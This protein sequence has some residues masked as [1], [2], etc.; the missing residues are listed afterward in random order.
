MKSKSAFKRNPLAASIGLE[1]LALGGVLASQLLMAPLVAAAPAGGVIVGGNGSINLGRTTNIEQT[2]H[3]LAINWDS[4]NV[5]S[6]EKVVFQQPDASALVLNRIL[7]QNPSKIRGSIVAN[8]NVLL[9][10]PRGIMFTETATVNVGGLVASGLDVSVDDFMNGNLVFKGVDGA[11]G[12]VINKGVINASSAAL[13]GKTVHNAPNALISADL[14]ALAAGDEAL[15]T[16][17]A[18]GLMGVKVTKEVL[19]NDL[20]LDDA[21]LN[22]GSIKGNK[23]LLEAAVSRD[24]FSNAVNNQGI[25]RAEGIDVSGGTIRLLGSGGQVTNG[26]D[27]SASGVSGGSISLAGDKIVN[28]GRM[29]AQGSAGDAQAIQID[30]RELHN[31]ST[32]DG[33]QGGM[34]IELGAEGGDSH[35]ILGNLTAADTITVTARGGEAGTDSF[36]FAAGGHY[37]L[38][39][40]GTV[41]TQGVTISGADKID[42]GAAGVLY[43]RDDVAESFTITGDQKLR[44]DAVIFS[45]IATV[46]AG[47]GDVNDSV[48]GAAQWALQGTKRASARGILF[49]DIEQVNSDGADIRITGRDQVAESFV[50]TGSRK[51]MVDEMTFSGV[52]A[53]NAGSG[54]VTDQVSGAV[55]WAL[56]GD[57]SV[58]AG[59]MTFRD[60]ENVSGSGTG[61][62]LTG[63]NDVAE[64]FAITGSKALTANRI[65]FDNISVVNAGSGAEPDRVT[66][67][68]QWLLNGNQ[69]IK[70]G[71]MTFSGVEAVGSL[72]DNSQLSGNVNNT[73]TFIL[74]GNNRLTASG[75]DFVGVDSVIGQSTDRVQD[76]G[77]LHYQLHSQTEARV[78]NLHLQ[79]LAL[80]NIQWDAGD[81]I[82]VAADH[83]LSGKT[84]DSKGAQIIGSGDADAFTVTG[85]NTV[86]YSEVKFTNVTRVDA[87]DGHD[88][89]VGAGE[90]ALQGNKSIHGHGITFS[91][92]EQVGGEAAESR[93]AGRADVAESFVITGSKAL[94]VEGIDF[95]NVGAVDGG[96]GA[97]T[98]RVSGASEWHLTGHQGV[99][100]AGITFTGIERADSAGSTAAVVGRDHVAE[101]FAVTGNRALTA[102]GIAFTN[103]AAVNAGDGTVSDSVSGA[104][105][106]QLQGNQSVKAEG[107]TFSSIEQAIGAGT[108][109]RIS[110][111]DNVAETFAITGSQTVQAEGIGFARVATVD[112][113]AGAATDSV[114][115]ADYWQLNGNQSVK[116]EG[117]TFTGVEQ[118][119]S[120]AMDS[121]IAGRDH[122]AESFVITGEK[123]LNAEGI[124]FTGVTAVDAGAGTTPDSVSGAAHWQLNGN[125][126]VIADGIVFSGV[127]QATGIES[128]SRISGRDQVAES[129]AMTGKQALA[130]DGI[131]FE[132]I[133]E[134]NAGSGAAADRVSGAVEWQLNGKHSVKAQGVT[135]HGV[136]EAGSSDLFARIKGQEG[137][138]E[139]FLL[140][141]HKAVTV[142]EIR[143]DNV[144]T[145]NAGTGGDDR[146]ETTVVVEWQLTPEQNSVQAAGMTF[147]GI[148]A[149]GFS[150]A[151]S[152]PGTLLG[153]AA[154]ETFDI[155]GNERYNVSVNGIAFSQIGSV[156]GGGG[157]N[158]VVS[159]DAERWSL[160]GVRGQV[161]SDDIQFSEVSSAG[162]KTGSAPLSTLRGSGSD[163]TYVLDAQQQTIEVAGIRFDHLEAVDA[164]GGLD[165][166][167]NL[168]ST[169]WRAA[170]QGG[171]WA[172]RSAEAQVNSVWLLFEN[173]EQVLNAGEFSGPSVGTDYTLTD[174]HAVRV[175]NIHFTGVTALHAGTGMDTLYGLDVDTDWTLHGRSGNT[176][177]LNFTGID[178]IRAGSARDIFTFNSGVSG[179]VFTGDG[180][181][182]VYLNGGSVAGLYL[183]GGADEL[184]INSTASTVSLLD[185]GA[186]HD[187]LTSNLAGLT[188]Q[189][190]G[191]VQQVNYL[192]DPAADHYAFTGFEILRNS[193]DWLRVNTSLAAEFALD[194]VMFDG[195]GISLDYRPAGDMQFSSQYRGANALTGSISG[196]SLDIRSAGD[197]DLNTRVDRLSIL[198]QDNRSIKVNVREAD[199]LVVGQIHAGAGGTISLTSMGLGA[200]TAEARGVT[201][202]KADTVNLG[203]E[204]QRWSA[205]GEQL[206]PLRME[207]GRAVNIVALSY[208]EPEFVH[209]IPALTA[210]GNRLQSVTGAVAAQGMKSAVQ[211]NVEEFTQV[212]PAIFTA[213]SPYSVNADALNAPEYAMVAGELVPAHGVVQASGDIDGERTTLKE[214][215]QE[216]R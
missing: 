44:A 117:I 123:A 94:R 214:E 78:A 155:S 33:G 148:K 68:T 96:S 17:D 118:A 182:T 77:D 203:S 158:R 79:G 85:S 40:G 193:A 175:G 80:A 1:A 204:W 84:I 4:F 179:D 174:A 165:S 87:L 144:E 140:T 202:L 66:G 93:V 106:W 2:S 128:G 177:H 21:L 159:A 83:A 100:A 183:Q 54:R 141:G 124:A 52:A 50:V 30:A 127:E 41:S 180:N 116:A 61:S 178:T 63:Q 163:E 70:A 72:G 151:V 9:V 170:E 14:V 12:A 188:W 138:S 29:A 101:L 18:D 47:S 69:S 102:E 39:E 10:N 191:D 95:T 195:A 147:T 64:L 212:D 16:F 36:S 194:R 86:D 46:N 8:G 23:V 67:S 48:S 134:V 153:S 65:A 185:G 122:V 145:V 20:G 126:S 125:Q 130:V 74:T 143:F 51:L 121:H 208:V 49:T 142:D 89:V 152:G 92:I 150:A 98:D 187:S 108:G 34:T 111:R 131:A 37:A 186:G 103:V 206:I 13:I 62:T 104:E 26:G 137:L 99:D 120:Q 146:V 109:S 32:I 168:Q 35:Q 160:S 216:T 201:H 58:I 119:G 196:G 43:G 149:A 171:S 3:N 190:H 132:K 90:W 167:H 28:E 176:Q 156:R 5:R 205:I 161:S 42:A 129:F 133:A 135:F 91:N 6:Y 113:G 11:S 173:I 71:D 76:G 110:G 105:H 82:A 136:E 115:G 112:A 97:V 38:S 157:S 211:A 73:E 209:G 154:D 162:V 199:N 198:N 19:E 166:V 75:M 213:V 184:F 59:G 139:S 25:V 45:N 88:S 56:N 164:G 215:E 207:V 169:R 210:T 189:I 55:Y 7:D 24:L 27:I 60:V 53:V 57:N 31:T 181:D 81:S 200:L 22:E 107:I 197:V 114:T 192:G 172:D 15:L